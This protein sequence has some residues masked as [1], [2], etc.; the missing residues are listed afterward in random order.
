[1]SALDSRA[2]TLHV[3]DLHQANGWLSRVGLGIYHS[4]VEIA[5]KEYTFSDDGV[6]HHAPKGAGRGGG[7]NGAPQITF[8]CS[9]PVGTYDGS[10]NHVHAI[11]RRLRE[12]DF[13]PGTYNIGTKN[14]NHFAEALVRELTGAEF[15]AWVN[16]AAGMGGWL[17]GP[18]AAKGQEA[19]TAAAAA[20]ASTAADAD[21]NKRREMTEQ[22]KALLAK[23]KGQPK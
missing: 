18:K 17:L 15:P 2:V 8:K 20:P 16:R 1:M 7:Q 21:R 10:F 4:G 5:G 13:Q 3:Y 6:F 23:M 19:S 11:V 14:C 12:T 9:V 22:Q